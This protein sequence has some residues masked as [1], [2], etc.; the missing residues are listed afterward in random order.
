MK[1]AMSEV[2]SYTI[3]KQDELADTYKYKQLPYDLALNC[4]RHYVTSLPQ[5]F[6]LTNNALKVAENPEINECIGKPGYEIIKEHKMPIVSRD[7]T[8]IAY[9]Y[10]RIVIGHYGA[11][12]EIDDDD[13]Y[14][15]NIKI[16]PKQE[17]RVFDRRYRDKVKYNWYTARDR[18]HCKLYFQK[19]EVAYADYKAN[20]WYISPFEVLDQKELEQ[21]LFSDTNTEEEVRDI[22]DSE[23][24]AED[25]EEEEDEFYF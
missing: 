5:G 20:M 18:S 7:G 3:K 2:G 13:I 21:L 11:Y 16:E 9:K 14:Q 23:G 24:D 12:I 19:K 15:D 8:M 25:Y 17:Y 1:Y 4:M 22:D 10:N 6:C